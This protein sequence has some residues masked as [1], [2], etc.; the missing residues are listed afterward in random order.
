MS[1]I[2]LMQ[3]SSAGSTWIAESTSQ[4]FTQQ[5][6]KVLWVSK[7]DLSIPS[8]SECFSHNYDGWYPE[9]WLVGL[10][11][12]DHTGHISWMPVI[13]QAPA[14]TAS[15]SVTNM[16]LTN[17]I[18]FACVTNECHWECESFASETLILHWKKKAVRWAWSMLVIY[19][20]LQFPPPQISAVYINTCSPTFL[21]HLA[22]IAFQQNKNMLC[23]L[24]YGT[25]PC[26]LHQKRLCGCSKRWL[27]EQ[28]TRFKLVQS[29]W[30]ESRNSLEL[31]TKPEKEKNCY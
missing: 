4:A 22:V 25:R 8:K 30:A 24:P 19:L 10:S 16:T 12:D 31:Y 9:D 23:M 26:L 15:S 2:Q 17:E 11:G 1:L 14:P 28:I 7:Q 5:V 6:S 18:F 20:Y 29:K 3:D 21:L 13:T 27:G